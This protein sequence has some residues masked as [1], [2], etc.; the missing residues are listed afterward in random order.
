M[1]V[2]PFSTSSSNLLLFFR[3]N[4]PSYQS[5]KIYKFTDWLEIYSSVLEVDTTVED[6]EFALPHLNVV[7]TTYKE[8][9]I[10]KIT[11]A[12]NTWMML[13]IFVLKL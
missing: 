8:F 7:Y 13:L 9:D 3:F 2:L 12:G 4:S 6:I 11:D 5:Y 1:H 10:F